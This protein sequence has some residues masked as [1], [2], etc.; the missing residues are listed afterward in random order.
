M[1]EH[2]YDELVLYAT[3]ITQHAH[4]KMARAGGS[5]LRK[6][7][8]LLAPHLSEGPVRRG[9]LAAVGGIR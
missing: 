7:V 2:G 6:V 5:K 8:T 3:T 4:G 1:V 9:L